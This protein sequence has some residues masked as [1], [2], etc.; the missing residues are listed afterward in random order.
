MHSYQYIGPIR[1]DIAA[2]TI[3]G[4]PPCPSPGRRSCRKQLA[5]TSSARSGPADL[6]QRR[7]ATGQADLL[8]PRHSPAPSHSRCGG[9]CSAKA[10]ARDH[11]GYL[12]L[13]PPREMKPA[14]PI[15]DGDLFDIVREA[16]IGRVLEAAFA[17]EAAQ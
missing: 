14:A 15:S 4:V 6:Y 12:P 2:P 8:R 16:G 17:V 7:R 5:P 10:T 13:V 1:V 11:A 9:H 3:V